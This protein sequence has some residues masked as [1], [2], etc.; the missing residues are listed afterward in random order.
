MSSPG[1]KKLSILYILEILRDY[2][3]E[4]HLLTQAEIARKLF[5]IYGLDVERKSIAANIDYL[6]DCGYDIIKKQSGCYLCGRE[7]EPSEVQ[8]L[9]DA[10]FSSKSINSKQARELANKFSKYLS[11]YQRKQYNYIYKLDEINRS[12]N[13]ELFYNIDII[14]EAIEN[15]KQ[16]C[17]NYRRFN[18]KNVSLKEKKYVVNPYFLV[19]NQGKYFLVCN[20]DYFDEIANYKVDRIYN[21]KILDK[22]L[23]PITKLK[24][25]EKG[26]DISKYINENI[27][28]F[29]TQTIEAVVKL[30]GER[31]PEQ[32]EEWFGKNARFFEKEN[33]LYASIRANETSLVYWCIQ[34]GEGVE[35][36]EPKETREKIKN[37]VNLIQKKYE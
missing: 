10:I 37:I 19:T 20:F 12:T 3:D 24:G 34:Y 8:F 36:I 21:I 1:S 26:F 11:I 6:I 30:F 23:K 4:N 29:S 14:N 7:F 5:N 27:Y 25:F 13:K 35:L 18:Y 16:I 2:S 28:M 22:E 15:K 32:V 33:E 17:F 31:T 9:V